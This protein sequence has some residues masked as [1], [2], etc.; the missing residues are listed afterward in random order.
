M[1]LKTILL[2]CPVLTLASCSAL[3]ADF[4]RGVQEFRAGRY[5]SAYGQFYTA[6]N[7][8]HPGTARLALHML[9]YGPLLY[10]GFWDASTEQVQSWV[11]SSRDPRARPVPTYQ[12]APVT[13]DFPQ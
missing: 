8:G 13:Q 6:A 4:D 11:Q 7:A 2:A 5:A 10:G 1:K 3:A 9:A 12:P